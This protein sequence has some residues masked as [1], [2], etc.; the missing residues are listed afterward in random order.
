VSNFAR[1]ILR[2]AGRSLWENLY[3]NI[4][5][6]GVIA[7]SLLLLGVFLTVQHNL[8]GIV[9]TWNRDVHVSAY[10]HPDIDE[11]RRFAL[12]D[13]VATQPGVRSVRYVSEADAEAWLLQRIDSLAPILEELGEGVLPASLEITLQPGAS[14]PAQ[15][16]AFATSLDAPSFARIDYGQEWV[17]RFNA[18]L[19]LLQA[20]GAILGLLILIAATFLVTNTV[21]LV[22]YNRRDELEVARLVG[23]SNS[24]ITLPF[25][26]EGAVQGFAGALLAGIGLVVVQRVVVL[27]L[28]D[29][30]ELDVA[31][32]LELLPPAQLVILGLAGVA[33]GVLAALFAVQRFLVRA[34]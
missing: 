16:S 25:V 1:H 14:Q 2:R 8:S 9:D 32:T 5:A 24:F 13:R 28:Q 20:L 10:F 15:I 27:R 21:H 12:R 7:A 11:E 30:L 4:V 33:L 23:A 22:V 26:I 19:S 29:A 34:P 31:G 3:L 18:F 17:E 6:G